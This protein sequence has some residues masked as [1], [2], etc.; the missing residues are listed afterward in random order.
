[1][2]TATALALLF[3]AASASGQWLE[4]TILLP[5]SLSG[6]PEPHFIVTNPLTHLV[7]VTGGGTN[8]I[9]VFDASSLRTVARVPL[10]TTA[11]LCIYPEVNKLYAFG[12][13]DSLISVVDLNVHRVVNTI[14]TNAAY[15][16]EAVCLSPERG[17]LYFSSVSLDTTWVLDCGSDSIIAAIP[18]SGWRLAYNRTAGKVYC[19]DGSNDELAVIYADNN[20]VEASIPLD[21]SAYAL[22]CNPATNNA[23]VG[24]INNDTVTVIDGAGDTVVARTSTGGAMRMCYNPFDSCVYAASQGAGRISVISGRDDTV[25]AL[26]PT[27]MSPFALAADSVSGKVYCVCEIGDT[28]T[29]VDGRTHQVLAHLPTGRMPWA[30]AVDP[31][32]GRAFCLNNMGVSV[33][34]VDGIGDSVVGTLA[35]G[36]KPGTLL[37]NSLRRRLY[38]GNGN[39]AVYDIY[40]SSVT[41]IDPDSRRVLRDIKVGSGVVALCWDS[42]GDRIYTAD[43]Y[44]GTVSV[45]DCVT[46]SCIARISVGLKPFALCY[47]PIRRR[48]FCANQ[49]SNT[50]SVIDCA[51]NTVTATYPTGRKPSALIYRKEGDKLYCANRRDSTL[52]IFTGDTAR[53]LIVRK[54]PWAMV[55]VDRYDRVYCLC[56]TSREGQGGPVVAVDCTNDSVIAIIYAGMNPEDICYNPRNVKVYTADTWS[57]TVTV[58]DVRTNTREAYVDVGFAPEDVLYNPLNNTVAVTD[59]TGANYGGVWFIDGTSN[60]VIDTVAGL[61]G[62]CALALDLEQNRVFVANFWGASISVIRDVVGIEETPEEPRLEWNAGATVLSGASGVVGA[63]SIVYDA[64]GRRVREP[65]PG[66]YFIREQIAGSS[67]QCR[68]RKVIIAR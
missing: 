8:A 25:I 21:L 23:Y 28:V 19:L 68:M 1:M 66:V 45:I 40:D 62:P 61:S 32:V 47:D 11:F 52:T 44:S 10:E 33:T 14:S 49:A 41:V 13:F 43:C 30:V 67:E 53:T 64:Q 18:A 51:T 17:R 55:Y 60:Q 2:K 36:R 42:I 50:V 56:N 65:G 4:T 34:V 26:L 22:V 12:E 37:F 35:V 6:Q 38:V 63:S 27:A 15:V 54:T 5:D 7:Y 58:I 16:G 39:D 59:K 46:V 48:I 20:T 3:L 31:D 57:S 29:I 24:N 9:T